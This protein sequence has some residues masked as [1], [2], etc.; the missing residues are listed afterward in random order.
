MAS[1][2][3]SP[4]LQPGAVLLLAGLLAWLAL[5]ETDAAPAAFDPKH[6]DPRAVALADQVLEALGGHKAWEGTHYIRF[7]FAVEKNGTIKARRT[8]LWD[9]WA[10]RLRYESVDGKGKP[11]IVLLDLN[12]RQG[13]AFRGDRALETAAARPLL[14]EAYEA[15]INDTYWLLMPYKM[16]DPGVRLQDA[17][18]VAIGG[19]TYDRVLLTFDNVGLT[20]KDRYW[21]H[22]NRRTHLMDRWSYVLQD[23]PPNSGPTVWDWKGWVRHGSILLAP[24]KVLVGAGDRV[25]ILHPVLE[26]ADS[27]PDSY[28]TRPDPLPDRLA[29]N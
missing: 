27:V 7:A 8:H 1:V 4:A 2:T 12:S 24:E 29:S 14:A 10:G 6:S 19:E 22:I 28:F 26:V 18:T 13:T 3:R 20:P 11:F 15:F 21:A 25:R 23:D 9:R 16:K 5:P 17:G